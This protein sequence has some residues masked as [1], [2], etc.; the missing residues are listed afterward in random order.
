MAQVVERLP[1][2]CEAF[3]SNPITAKRKFPLDCYD[4]HKMPDSYFQT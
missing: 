1:G 2:R 4:S 3:S